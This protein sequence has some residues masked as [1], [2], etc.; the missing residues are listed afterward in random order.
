[1]AISNSIKKNQSVVIWYTQFYTHS[2]SYRRG[3]FNSKTWKLWPYLEMFFSFFTN[4]DPKG[5]DCLVWLV[6]NDDKVVF[7]YLMKSLFCFLHSLLHQK[8]ME[9]LYPRKIT[10][11]TTIIKMMMMKNYS[12]TI[13]M[14][15][16]PPWLMHVCC[17]WCINHV[18]FCWIPTFANII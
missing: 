4:I 3:Y 18:F 15:F 6:C 14:K 17:C 12:A 16:H 11:T 8:Q 9:Y 13:T 10:T 1:M 2:L 5:G 7:L